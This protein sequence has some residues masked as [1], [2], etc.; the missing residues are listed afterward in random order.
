MAGNPKELTL[1]HTLGPDVG[2]LPAPLLEL[3][4]QESDATEREGHDENSMAADIELVV[5]LGLEDPEDPVVV[6]EVGECSE[7][8]PSLALSFHQVVV[9]SFGN[10]SKGM[11]IP[12]K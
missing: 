7:G 2:G 6:G 4:L 11:T 8:V 1:P 5:D 9:I 3:L 12:Q 10:A